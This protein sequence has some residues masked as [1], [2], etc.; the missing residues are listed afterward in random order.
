MGDDRE[1]IARIIEEMCD[2]C[3]DHRIAAVDAILA[4]QG[5]GPGEAVAKFDAELAAEI[6]AT[7][8]ANPSGRFS[9]APENR[10]CSGVPRLHSYKRGLSHD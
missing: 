2:P 9:G 4:R 1:E 5:P 10:V 6:I 7:I 8:E 3:R